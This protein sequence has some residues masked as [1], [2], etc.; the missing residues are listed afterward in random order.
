MKKLILTAA[1]TVMCT[2][3]FAQ[4]LI[5][6]G[7]GFSGTAGR[8][9]VFGP[10]TTDANRALQGQP[11]GTLG[12]PTGTTVYTGPLLQGT[13]YTMALFAGASTVADAD[14]LAFVTAVGFRT[15]AANA[16]PAGLVTT[17]T[18][19]LQGILAGSQAHIEYRAWDNKGGTITTWD[20]AVNGSA[21][22]GRSGMFTTAA[23][24][25]TDPGGAI[26]LTPNGV[27]QSFNIHLVPEPSTMALAGLAAA[28]LLIF[29]RRK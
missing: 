19:P 23:L 21:A 1:V 24:G 3:T 10:D 16:L 15:A 25:G 12:V 8:F 17:A 18:I 22:W 13:G 20:Q 14:S 28:G 6:F 2:A 7:N 5:N 27:A 29:R 26:V 4:G 9:P 11:S